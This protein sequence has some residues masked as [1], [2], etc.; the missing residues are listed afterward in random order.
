MAESNDKKIIHELNNKKYP[1]GFVSNLDSDTISK[2]LNE[3]TVRLISQKK[4]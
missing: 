4:K 2:G 3:D 1:Y